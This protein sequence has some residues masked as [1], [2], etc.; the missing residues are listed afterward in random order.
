[1]IYRM[2]DLMIELMTEFPEVLCAGMILVFEG[3]LSE[4]IASFGCFSQ[5]EHN[6]DDYRRSS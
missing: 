6:D 2:I 5:Y 3:V 1:M 4:K